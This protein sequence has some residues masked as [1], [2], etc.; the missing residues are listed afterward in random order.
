MPSERDHL[1]SSGE[2]AEA[3]HAGVET[4]PFTLQPVITRAREGR[5]GFG[6]F[7]QAHRQVGT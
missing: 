5:G 7:P 6:V 3:G 2:S 1:S 4:L